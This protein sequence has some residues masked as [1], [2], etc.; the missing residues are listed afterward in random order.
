MSIHTVPLQ[1]AVKRLPDLFNLVNQGDDVVI[2]D[3]SG[4]RVR[5]IAD[6]LVS[7]PRVAD[8]HKG[9]IH[10]RDDFDEPL[11]DSFLLGDN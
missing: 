11:D 3:A 7:K 6:T 9:K 5:L 10:M 2:T 4:A 1:D 8:L